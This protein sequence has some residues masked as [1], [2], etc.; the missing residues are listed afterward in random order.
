[1]REGGPWLWAR[2]ALGWV[3]GDGFG[4]SNKVLPCLGLFFALLTSGKSLPILG[5]F[6]YPLK[7]LGRGS[8]QVF[9]RLF[10]AWL[11]GNS[12]S[13]SVR[14]VVEG[15]C[16]FRAVS[17]SGRD[18]EAVSWGLRRPLCREGGGGFGAGPPGVQVTLLNR[19]GGVAGAGQDHSLF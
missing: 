1:M 6:L 7:G 10:P 16:R 2:G 12:V 9:F 17:H 4:V 11:G 13:C 3:S 19:G 18:S 8:F 15:C 14:T 5:L